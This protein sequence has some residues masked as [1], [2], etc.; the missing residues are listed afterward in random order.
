MTGTPLPYGDSQ[1]MPRSIG[2]ILDHGFT[3]ARRVAAQLLPLFVLLAA[4]DAIPATWEENLALKGLHFISGLG[5]WLLSLAYIFIIGAEWRGKQMTLS[6]AF[7]KT[8]FSF[9]VKLTAFSVRVSLV[10]VFCSIFL[11]IPGLVYF[12]NR[13]V[14][15]GSIYFEGATT[16]EALAKSKFLM[17]QESWYSLKGAKMRYTAVVV[18]TLVMSMVVQGVSFLFFGVVDLEK[19]PTAVV[20]PLIFTVFVSVGVLTHLIYLY[21]CVLGVGFYFDL[22]TRYEAMDLIETEE[23]NE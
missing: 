7:R 20:S 21:S 1:L 4:V 15:F 8:S 3:V 6:Q 9:I 2:E 17:S 14:A 19:L 16:R 10:T 11:I 5:G 12:I 18:V 22:R 13:V 23:P